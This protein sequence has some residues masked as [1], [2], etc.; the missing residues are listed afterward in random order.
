LIGAVAAASALLL[1]L[2]NASWVNPYDGR[3]VAFLVALGWVALGVA[4]ATPLLDHQD[5]RTRARLV[6]CATAVLILYPAYV[7][8]AWYTTESAAGRTNVPYRLEATRLADL[9]SATGTP[10]LLDRALED[11]ELGG[12]G[13]GRRALEYLVRLQGAAPA[14]TDES[15]M[16][17]YMAEPGSRVVLV[18]ARE[19]AGRLGGDWLDGTSPAWMVLPVGVAVPEELAPAWSGAE[20]FGSA[21]GERGGIRESPPP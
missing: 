16:R 12:G 8:W 18:A 21:D 9:G 11:L 1:P 14:P 4:S 13:N 20:P 15:E 10:I 7:S 2:F 3:Y 6:S 19:T 17:W 5:Q